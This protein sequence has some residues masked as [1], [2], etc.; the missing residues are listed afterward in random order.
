MA[1]NKTHS[2]ERFK[3][4]Y[5]TRL[6]QLKDEQ[7]EQWALPK[8]ANAR[9]EKAEID[10]DV[11]MMVEYFRIGN[12]VTVEA[13]TRHLERMAQMDEHYG[14]CARFAECWKRN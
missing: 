2:M 3:E 10:L 5:Q 14:V 12:G 6:R 11:A 8:T 1:Q 13:V 7:L 9:P 4:E